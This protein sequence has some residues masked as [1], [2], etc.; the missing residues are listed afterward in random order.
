MNDQSRSSRPD[1]PPLRIHHLLVCAAVVA[2]HFA[3]WRATLPADALERVA[4]TGAGSLA[5]FA[6]SHMIPAVGLTLAI[7]S[8]Y[9]HVKGYAGLVQPGQWLLIA[10]VISMLRW[11][12][13]LFAPVWS[14]APRSKNILLWDFADAGYSAAY[15]LAWFISLLLP[16]LFF[17]W[18]AWRI[19]DTRSWRLLFALKALGYLLVFAPQFLVRQWGWSLGD[20]FTVLT[21]VASGGMMLCAIWAPANDYVHGIP[22]TWTHWVGIGLFIAQHAVRFIAFG[23]FSLALL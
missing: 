12:S 6:A 3:L 1:P 13:Q 14:M 23:L 19:A 10:L 16:M 9:W 2:A 11:I 22:R 5:L 15:L 17:G 20:A 18:L 4:T 7:F 8:A 21:T